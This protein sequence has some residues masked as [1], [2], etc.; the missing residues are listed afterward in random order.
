MWE[1]EWVFVLQKR[2]MQAGLHESLAKYSR[3]LFLNDL[4]APLVGKVN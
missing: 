4:V 2:H 1:N 3:F